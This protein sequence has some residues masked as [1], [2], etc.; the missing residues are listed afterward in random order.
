M[1]PKVTYIITPIADCYVARFV[2][3]LYKYSEPDSFRLIIIDQCENQFRKEVM[4]YV[5]PL[6]HLYIHPYR[7][8]GYAKAM[9]EGALHAL[10]WGTPLICFANDDIEIIDSRWMDGI[11]KTFEMDEKI[12]GVIPMSPRVA[13]F[14]YGV[15]YNPEVLPY[16]TE[17]TKEE[18]DY[19]LKG[20][21]SDTKGLPPT[22]P[23]NQANS[24]V[25]GGAFI[26]PYF[27]RELLEEVGLLDERYFPGSGEDYDM[28]A[29]TY[30]K[31][32]RIV[33]TSQSWVYH[34][35]GKS[36]DL[37][38][39]GELERKYYKNRP[40]W[41]NEGEIWPEGFDIWGRDKEGN[42]YPRVPEVFVDDIAY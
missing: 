32:Y 14:G 20:D 38:A 21:F 29:R 25:D 2:Y 4:D 13:G 30:Q 1:T 42:Q 33:S 19:L 28:L 26:M 15:T 35:W 12:M 41:N 7:N 5:L 34:L 24:L 17:Y 9:S 37:F 27:K 16:K 8:L 3:T 39:S 23:T 10:H 36:K 31:G 22:M 40:Y 18:Y 6:T 11:Y